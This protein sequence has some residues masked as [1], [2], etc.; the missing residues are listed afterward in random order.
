MRSRC[1]SVPPTV[2]RPTQPPPSLR[3][4]SR[5]IVRSDCLPRVPWKNGAGTTREVAVFPAPA[6]PTFW[7]RIS[8]ADIC[9]DAGF[10]TFAGADRHFVVASP[11]FLHLDVDGNRRNVAHYQPEAFPGEAQVSVKLVTGPTTA[12][13]LITDRSTCAGAIDVQH[14]DGHL[15]PHPKAVALVLL[16]GSAGTNDG[17]HLR[18]LDVLMLGAEWERI[19]FKKAVVATV[20]VWDLPSES[21][22]KLGRMRLTLG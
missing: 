18:P 14:L 7:W 13:N 2:P 6:G 21:H 10:S 12:I 16:A 17:L 4:P 19:L 15:I 1:S 22:K 9:E 11:G 5:S 3:L 8:V 20:S